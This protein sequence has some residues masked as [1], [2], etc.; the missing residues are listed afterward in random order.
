[1]KKIKLVLAS[2]LLLP[3]ISFAACNPFSPNTVLTASALNN[4]IAAPCITS[5]TITGSSINNTPIG[6]VTRSTGAFTEVTTPAIKFGGA[7]IA[8]VDANGMT[9]PTGKILGTAANPD[10]DTSIANAL[11]GGHYGQTWQNL[12]ASRALATTYTN[13]TGKII[14]V[15]VV[16]QVT[17]GSGSV[18]IAPTVAGYVMTQQILYAPGVGYQFEQQ[19]D[20]PVGATYSIGVGG[21]GTTVILLEWSEQRV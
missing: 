10:I 20:V 14:K 3:A 12:T 11:A 9:I 15:R 4:A 7:T 5:G 2:L 21:S 1:M 13:N 17:A 8:I 18:A 19:I 6:A 16:V